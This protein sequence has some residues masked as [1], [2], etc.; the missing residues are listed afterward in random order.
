MAKRPF[1]EIPGHKKFDAE[2]AEF[3]SAGRRVANT[4]TAKAASAKN[5]RERDAF[6]QIAAMMEEPVKQA[7]A[8]R[9]LLWQATE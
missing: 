4:A 9:H 8:A 1:A 2:I 7:V 6:A 3:I 5:K